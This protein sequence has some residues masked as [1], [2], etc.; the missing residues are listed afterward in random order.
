MKVI[1]QLSE[2]QFVVELSDYDKD[3]TRTRTISLQHDYVKI[4]DTNYIPSD[5]SVSIDGTNQSNIPCRTFSTIG[6]RE[7]HHFLNIVKDHEFLKPE[8]L[9][10]RDEKP[11]YTW[12]DEYTLVLN[13]DGK[14]R[15]FARDEDKIIEITEGIWKRLIN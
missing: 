2:T 11:N 8:H 14:R 3:L 15:Y 7:F 1:K 9:L 10:G 13:I 6:I 5:I 4:E 12:G